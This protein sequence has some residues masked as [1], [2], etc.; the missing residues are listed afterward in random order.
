[1]RISLSAKTKQRFGAAMVLA[2]VAMGT[3]SQCGQAAEKLRFPGDPVVV[4][5]TD[6]GPIKVEVYK[7][8]APISSNNFLDLVGRKFYN[9]LTFHR[10]VP[11]FVIQGGDPNG[12]GSGDFVDPQ[13]HAKRTIPLEKKPSLNHDQP[14]TL[15]M[16]RSNNPNSAS[17]QFYITLDSTP[18][19]DQPPGYAVFGR[20]ISGMPVVKQIQIGD[21]MKK[22]YVE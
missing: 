1:M 8:E 20:V 13:T 6:K 7:K 15:A 2:A 19:L 11:G 14:G 21:K 12:D 4:I 22:V 5:D 18:N 17:C 3:F 10:V 9:G 16:A